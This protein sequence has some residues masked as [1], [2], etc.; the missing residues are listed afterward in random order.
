MDGARLMPGV[1]ELAPAPAVCPKCDGRGFCLV[2]DGLADWCTCTAAAELFNADMQFVHDWNMT[3]LRRL[4]TAP[5]RAAMATAV[6][7]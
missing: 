1:H 6:A 7:S 3:Q 5:L 4:Q 2:G